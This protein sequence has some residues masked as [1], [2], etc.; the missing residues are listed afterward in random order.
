[1]YEAPTQ[2]ANTAIFNQ[3]D[4][5]LRKR[6]EYEIP[7]SKERN[8]QES[9]YVDMEGARSSIPAKF[10][11]YVTT[12]CHPEFQAG[13]GETFCFQESDGIPYYDSFDEYDDSEDY[14]EMSTSSDAIQTVRI[15]CRAVNNTCLT[16]I[17]YVGV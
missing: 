15:V 5:D 10:N 12:T 1:M 11:E 3:L 17:N 9:V 4:K 8:S 16:A 7:I 13:Q 14:A 2:R 6:G